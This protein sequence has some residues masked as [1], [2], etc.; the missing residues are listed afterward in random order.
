MSNIVE[1]RTITT[2]PQ[3][4]KPRTA[5]VLSAGGLFAA[6]QA[7]VYEALWPHWKPD[8]VVGASAG[9]LNGVPVA[10]RIEP[11]ELIDLWRHPDSAKAIAIRPRPSLRHGYF[12]PLP[13]AER[14]KRMQREFPRVLPFGVVAIEVPRFR[15][16][17]FRDGEITPRHLVATCSIPLFYPLVHIDGRRFTD[18]GLLEAMP[19]WAAAEMGA[20]Q[21]IAINALPRLTPLPIH[22]MLTAVH[23]IRRMPVPQT[24]DVKVITCPA[25]MGRARDAM[26]WDKE[27]I[28]RWIASG[29]RDGQKF[30]RQMEQTQLAGADA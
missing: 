4:P 10:A 30:L 8:L 21:A 17:L 1:E 13:L 7:G 26:V 25:F 16:R 6:Y 3:V 24:L 19:L 23:R 14:A 5:L 29:I 11:R 15:P 2:K 28:D 18:G 9:A 20:T 27:N 12:D 22:L